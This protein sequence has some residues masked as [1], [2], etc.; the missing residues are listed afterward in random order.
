MEIK[1]RRIITLLI[2]VLT[3]ITC[4]KN[5]V[6]GN[7]VIEGTVKHHS[8]VIKDATVFLKFKATDQPAG[9][10]TAYDAKVRVDA[11]GYFKFNVYKGQYYIYGHGFDYG[12]P[13]PYIVAG[14]QGVK[15][16]SKETTSI[17]LFVTEGD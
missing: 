7:A 12:I 10:T 17:T 3:F 16:R 1:M 8:K 5:D 9:D 11:N 13:A 15:L 6:G 4:K 14:G 2:V